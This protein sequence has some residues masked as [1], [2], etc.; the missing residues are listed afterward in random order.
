MS[1]NDERHVGQIASLV[2]SHVLQDARLRP[3]LFCDAKPAS[4]TVALARNLFRLRETRDHRISQHDE[5]IVRTAR[6]S[7]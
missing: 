2:T 7:V 3:E 5:P 6:G 1:D 4:R